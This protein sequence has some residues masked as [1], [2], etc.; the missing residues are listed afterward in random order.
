MVDEEL[1]ALRNTPLDDFKLTTLHARFAVSDGPEGLRPALQELRAAAV[2]AVDEGHTVLVISDRL[3]DEQWAPIPMLLAVSTVHHHLIR[4]GRR[5]RASIIAETGD[6]RDVHHFGALI[7]FGASAVNPYV[8]FETLRQLV[9]EGDRD[10]DGMT[11]DEVLSTY[12]QAVDI[13][14]L[15]VMSKMGISA[16]SSYHGAQIFEALGINEG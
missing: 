16:V 13:G 6:A 11:L 7:G 15:K 9:Q 8:A 14:I 12:E 10:L 3:T 5:M 1:A 2:L 4:R